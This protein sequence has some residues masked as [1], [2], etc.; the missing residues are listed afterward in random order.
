MILLAI[1]FPPV[2]LLVM[3]RW[4]EFLIILILWLLAFPAL[5]FFIVPGV[6]LLSFCSIT[7]MLYV[8]Q[9]STAQHFDRIA[10][11]IT[12]ASERVAPEPIK[13]EA[14]PARPVAYSGETDRAADEILGDTKKDRRAPVKGVYQTRYDNQLKWWRNNWANRRKA[15]REY[16]N[17][18]NVCVVAISIFGIFGF[19]YVVPLVNHGMFVWDAVIVSKLTQVVSRSPE[20]PNIVEELVTVPPVVRKERIVPKMDSVLAPPEQPRS[21]PSVIIPKSDTDFKNF[22]ICSKRYNTANEMGSLG[23]AS[24]SDFFDK[25]KAQIEPMTWK[26]CSARADAKGLSGEE[27]YNFRD[28]CKK[29]LE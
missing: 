4:G 13:A 7:A 6:L 1:L 23:G 20:V 29:G 8:H 26:E 10:S 12:K 16:F 11:A 15:I 27:R 2:A 5:F 9:H 24:W 18:R 22:V 17:N 28:R 21:T 25:C 3:R 19:V 14:L